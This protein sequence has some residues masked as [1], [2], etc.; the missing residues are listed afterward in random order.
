MSWTLSRMARYVS[1]SKYLQ[2]L[3]ENDELCSNVFEKSRFLMF[4][5]DRPLLTTSSKIA[6]ESSIVSTPFSGI[7]SFTSIHD[8]LEDQCVISET[9]EYCEDL[10][11]T[12]VLLTIDESTEDTPIFAC[13]VSDPS[14]TEMIG[15]KFDGNFIDMRMAIFTLPEDQCNLVSRVCIET[16]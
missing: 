5:R 8:K 13:R 10:K 12:S 3:K 2:Q 14:K 11:K 16:S 7:G 9:I 4:S 6:S 1:Q 15:R